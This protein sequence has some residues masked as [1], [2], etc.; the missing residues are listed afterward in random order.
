LMMFWNL[1]NRID[2]HYGFFTGKDQ[3]QV[4]TSSGE[5]VWN[6]NFLKNYGGHFDF[7]WERGGF[8]KEIG[9][10]GHWEK[11][12]IYNEEF[13]AVSPGTEFSL[14]GS[15]SLRPRSNLELSF[16]ADW[17]NQKLSDSG[18]TV[19]DGLTYETSIHYQVTR[20]LFLTARLLGE[21]REDQYNFDFLIG[22]YFGAGNLIQLSFK[23]SQRK[24]FLVTEK[25]HSFTFKLS[26]LFR[27]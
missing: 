3:Y 16:E 7:G 24:E 15:L 17:I 18:Q 21:T 5:L 27:L 23:Q 2:F 1:F 19:F 6:G 20:E 25:G 4:L 14:E 26:Y 9:L 22:Y 13:T 12:G 8:L 11:R 10:E